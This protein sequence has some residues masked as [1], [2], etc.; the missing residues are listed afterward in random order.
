M[1]ILISSILIMIIV[2]VIFFLLTKKILKAI[3]F[4]IIF[5]LLFSFVSGIFIY[6]DILDFQQ[7]FETGQKLFLLESNNT[8][9]TGLN[10]KD[11]QDLNI[12]TI[13]TQ[14]QIDNMVGK[15]NSEIL[16]NNYKLFIFD[17]KTFQNIQTISFWEMEFTNSEIFSLLE[18]STP[19]NT[20]ITK[21]IEKEKYPETMRQSLTQEFKSTMDIS[22]DA[23]MKGI[24]FMLLL[25]EKT[26][27]N[28]NM[29]FDELKKGNLK[30]YPETIIFKILKMVPQSLLEKVKSQMEVF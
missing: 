16:K 6:L 17:S 19:I 23:Q 15:S 26:K 30:I 13:L 22:D 2:G 20:I 11:M 29:I 27:R 3:G 18:S 5:M 1:E 10:I 12:D 9:V 28:K 14:Q 21:I 7:N 4:T 24:L 8:Y 25:E